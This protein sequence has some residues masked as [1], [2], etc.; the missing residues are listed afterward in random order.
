M[1]SL[2]SSLH[3]MPHTYGNVFSTLKYF[4]FTPFIQNVRIVV[5]Q[6]FALIEATIAALWDSALSLGK[7]RELLLHNIGD[8][9]MDFQ[10]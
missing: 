8:F 1:C 2:K 7:I 3:L 6:Y 4:L 10:N 9:L 5:G